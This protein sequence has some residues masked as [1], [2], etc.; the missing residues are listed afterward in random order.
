[1]ITLRIKYA[2]TAVNIQ[3]PC[4]DNVLMAKLMELHAA[5]HESDPF[6]VEKVIDPG[7]IAPFFETAFVDL[8]KANYLAKRMENF[9]DKEINQF[10]ATSTLEGNSTVKDLINLTVSFDRYPL[11]SEAFLMAKIFITN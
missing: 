11:I 8:D 2:D 5:D 4:T 3:F 10:F 9:M 6:F 7:D 1:M